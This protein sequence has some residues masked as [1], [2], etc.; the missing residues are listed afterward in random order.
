MCSNYLYFIMWKIEG[1]WNNNS[2]FFIYNEYG[3]LVYNNNN[4]DC[5]GYIIG[6]K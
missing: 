5:L 2:K 4:I 1:M 6:F 3:T